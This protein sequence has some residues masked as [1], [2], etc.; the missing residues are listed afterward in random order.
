MLTDSLLCF[1]VRQNSNWSKVFISNSI[2]RRSK[3][4]KLHH[5]RPH[6]Q[7]YINRRTSTFSYASMLVS[8]GQRTKKS[9]ET[10]VTSCLTASRLRL[11]SKRSSPFE[12]SGDHVTCC[13]QRRDDLSVQDN[14]TQT[15]Q[16][17]PQS[18]ET[19]GFRA[20]ELIGITGLIFGE[21]SSSC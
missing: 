8:M 14:L 20:D 1:L 21:D 10:S 12:I 16:E 6:E 7:N 9:I 15:R 4:S 5:A 3:C 19:Q 13:G 18:H 11:P 2:I 17:L